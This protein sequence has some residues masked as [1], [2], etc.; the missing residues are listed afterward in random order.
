M[1]AQEIF[2][3]VWNHFITEKQP[4]SFRIDMFGDRGCMYR[5][6]H[7]NRCAI[8]VLIP[9]EQY[10]PSIE[11]PTVQDLLTSSDCPASLLALREHAALL[12]FL[13]RAHD[14]AA[15]VPYEGRYAR[16]KVLLVATA[17]THGLQV[18]A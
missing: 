12:E 13:Q 1:T 7:G 10:D 18:S 2:D 17:L 14:L 11:G 16:L 6:A 8:G 15:G 9:D 4:L 3:R 5:D